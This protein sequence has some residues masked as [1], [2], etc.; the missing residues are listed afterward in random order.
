LTRFD[1]LGQ[2][3][4]GQARSLT[5]ASQTVCECQLQFDEARLL[6]TQLEKISNGSNSPARTF[7]PRSL[8][9]LRRVRPFCRGVVAA[10]S[11]STGI[12]HRAQSPLGL[13]VMYGEDHDRVGMRAVEDSPV[14]I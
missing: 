6:I 1:E 3:S 14:V 11:S 4:L 13:L 12:Q 7:E 10:E 2:R 5:L 8:G 9:L